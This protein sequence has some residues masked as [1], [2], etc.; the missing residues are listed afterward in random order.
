MLKDW[1][2]KGADPSSV[3]VKVI[4]MPNRIDFEVDAAEG[5]EVQRLSLIVEFTETLISWRNH[6]YTWVDTSR[7]RLAAYYSPKAAVFKSGTK[8]V[9]SRT[10]G[11]W[12]F[13]PRRPRSIEW[14]LEHEDLAPLFDYQED[15]SSA[16]REPVR[17]LDKP[18]RLTFLLTKGAIPE[19]SR[20]KLP[21]SAI[22]CFTDHCDFDSLP[23]L[24]AQ[25][26][27]FAKHG[28]RVTKGVF[29]YHYSK[30]DF[31]TSLERNADEYELWAADG[32]ELCYHSL[33]QS[34]RATDEE[35]EKDFED[36]AVDG[37]SWQTWID[38]GFQP[39]NFTTHKRS[40]ID[41]DLWA[42]MMSRAG[43]RYLWNY[44]DCGNAGPGMINQADPDTV[45]FGAYR[46]RCFSKPSAKAFMDLFR[47]YILFFGSEKDQ[48]LYRKLT[49]FIKI[50]G[51]KYGLEGAWGLI[52][53]ILFL[54]KQGVKLL[55]T[56]KD[57]VP[58]W[59]RFTPLFFRERIGGKDFTFFQ[60]LE[61]HDFIQS[62]SETNVRQLCDK[63]GVCLAH[64]YFADLDK[65]KEGRIF[66][67][68]EGALIPGI[69]EVFERIA[70]A[71]TEGKLWI[72]TLAEVGERFDSFRHLVY[73]IDE[74][75]NIFH[76]LEK[77]VQELHLRYIN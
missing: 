27:L 70:A 76:R 61:V 66:V 32:H 67:N 3:S 34:T 57:A 21:F 31:N 25:R 64:T 18:L 65:R 72:A 5:A 60:T 50:K 29:L 59:Q 43:I 75:G 47:S 36:F 73:D 48:M 46:R 11:L 71:S 10:D 24:M 56:R 22:L 6:D 42:E 13:D 20:S 55:M 54:A 9:A 33:S 40:G 14:V 2:I 35:W 26:K 39:Y 58:H 12:L 41:A 7:K 51:W 45:T 37:R 38:H 68:G 52:R 16:F 74:K 8:V 23:L 4:S 53:S 44:L 15:D 49:F 30:R 19:F 63:A 28:I 17:A 62:F 69:D 77:E 1:K